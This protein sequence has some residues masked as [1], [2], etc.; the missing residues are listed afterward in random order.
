MFCCLLQ[1]ICLADSN[2]HNIL[3]L[4]SYHQ[5]LEWTDNISSGILEVFHDRTDV[6][7]VF[8][9]LD[10]KRNFNKEYY[11]E[12]YMLYKVKNRQIPFESIIVSDNAAFEFL[13]KYNDEFYPGVP[14]L[15][16]GINDLDTMAI[17]QADLFIGTGE[18]ADHFGTLSAIERVFPTRKNV[19]IINDNTLTGKKIR[20]ELDEVIKDF[21][22][23]FNF[24]FESDFTI[25]SLQ[26]KVNT[27]DDSFVIYL[28]VINHDKNGK[29]ISYRKGI[30]KIKEASTVPIFGSW[31]F[32]EG[33]GL[34]G[35]KIT[36]GIEQGKYVANIAEQII[37]G[38]S[39]DEFPKY[40]F[41]ESN[42]V[43]DHVE[44]VHFGV[45][46]A[47]LPKNSIIINKPGWK[48]NLLTAALIV[49]AFL[50]LSLLVVLV[51]LRIKRGRMLKMERLITERTSD[52]NEM[53][54]ELSDIILA[55]DKFFS[56]LAHDLR[57]SVGM[58]QSYTIL[59]NNKEYIDDSASLDL[60]KHNL[61]IAANQTF[62][63]VEDLLYWGY[64]QF[65]NNKNIS[66]SIFKLNIE[67]TRILENYSLNSSNVIFKTNF[68]DGLSLNSDKNICCFIFRNILQNGIKYSNPGDVID[69][70]TEKIDDGV[71]VSIKDSGIGM[72]QEIIDSIYKKDHL[73]RE[74]L[75]GEKSMGMGLATVMDYLDVINGEMEIISEPDKGSEFIIRLKNM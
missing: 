17:Q 26:E 28:L 73:R 49:S 39:I 36:R 60:L 68:L 33:K 19:L 31:D 50:F 18:K 46:K 55:K 43:F 66:V 40:V 22:G 64:N 5:G 1:T 61:Q 53:N 13:K 23:K 11:D 75:K 74:G 56:I 71:M 54:K 65:K 38:A 2:E 3:V 27:L 62:G 35:G 44:M 16:C 20:R 29:F 21:E 59:L 10:T 30:S 7:L 8:E 41:L 34:F 42:Y 14:I 9:Y 6:N 48:D 51:Q 57:S 12:L 4:H 63:I 67:I 25:E 24:E 52:L 69:I 45:N 70:M 47:K 15:Y 37:D 32:Y 58:F 72:S